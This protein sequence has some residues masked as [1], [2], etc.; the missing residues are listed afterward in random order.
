MAAK[1]KNFQ[2]RTAAVDRAS[3]LSE[4][5]TAAF[6]EVQELRKQMMKKVVR[7][8]SDEQK[9]KLPKSMRHLLSGN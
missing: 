1:I 2:D 9:G 4:D 8:L 5:Q 3:G 6:A 7:L